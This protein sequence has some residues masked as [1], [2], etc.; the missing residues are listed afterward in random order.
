MSKKLKTLE[1]FTNWLDSEEGQASIN[2]TIAEWEEKKQKN[3]DFFE[4]KKF[5]KN[6]ANIKEYLENEDYLSSMHCAYDSDNK[7]PINGKQFDKTFA[8]VLETQINYRPE[9]ED[10]EFCHRVCYYDNLRFS[11][12]VGQGGEWS[13]TRCDKMDREHVE[14]LRIG[15]MNITLKTSDPNSLTIKVNDKEFKY[16][17]DV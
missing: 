3:I 11:E 16:E 6:I 15:M 5:H 1:D 9:K 2:K 8:S 13:I 12:Y 7:I 10:N 4:S 17:K 14:H